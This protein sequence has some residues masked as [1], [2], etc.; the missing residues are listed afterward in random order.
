M[1]HTIPS[2]KLDDEVTNHTLS[3]ERKKIVSIFLTRYREQDDALKHVGCKDK[4]TDWWT[5]KLVDRN[6]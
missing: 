5:E 4:Y 2:I 1:K 6:P 3:T